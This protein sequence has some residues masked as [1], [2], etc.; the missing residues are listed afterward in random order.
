MVMVFPAQTAFTPAGRPVGVPMPVAPVV[1]MV[2]AG[3]IAVLTHKVGLAE[4]IPAVLMLVMVMVPL[5]LTFPHP[6]VNGME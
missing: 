3:A 2:M 5:A 1:A 6:P 4:G